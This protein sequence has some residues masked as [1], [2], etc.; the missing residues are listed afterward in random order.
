[1]EVYL[2]VYKIYLINLKIFKIKLEVQ[3]KIGE[4]I[5]YLKLN[6]QLFHKKNNL[7]KKWVKI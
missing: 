4:V 6:Y 2:Q 7:F 5:V 3:M 1:M